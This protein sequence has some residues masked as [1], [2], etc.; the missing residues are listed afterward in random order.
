MNRIFIAILV[1]FVVGVAVSPLVI[2]LTKKLKAKQNIYEYVDM[3][4]SKQGTPTMGGIGIIVSI[5]VG[6]V[7]AFYKNN[8]LGVISLIVML[9]FGILGFLDDFLKI[10][11]KRNLGL[12]AYQK[13]I[14]QVAI[15]LIITIFAYQ[16]AF[17]G[18]S[19][20]LPF[21]QT[22]ISLSW[23]FLPLCLIVFIA[24]TNAVNL[25]DGLDGLAGGVSLSYL[26]GFVFVCY[27][28]VQKQ[29]LIMQAELVN[30]QMNLLVVGGAG[31]GGLLAYLI[32][33]CFPA[34]IFMGDT[35]SLC[36]GGLIS[37][38]AIFLKQPLLILILG[39]MFVWSA[40]SVIIQ[41]VYFKLTKK[42]VFLM[43]PF[44]HHLEKKGMNENRIVVIYIVITI[45]LS[46]SS[47]LLTLLLA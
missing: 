17:V 33:N 10:Y 26:F 3:H 24:T 43:A 40:L 22:Q 18:S 19:I 36:L 27:L 25:T 7:V 30:E 21:S 38:L 39:A 14:G 29:S 1:S 4:K 23:W 5:V 41:V 47:I 20:Y 28:I 31:I 46:V 37:S 9:M 16:N 6:S 13:I 42:R 2:F 8:S 32:Y 35:G 12:R 44:H 34:K 15:S 11:N 45:I